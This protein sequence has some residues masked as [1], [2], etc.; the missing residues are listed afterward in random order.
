MT[1]MKKQSIR[2]WR[3][4]IRTKNVFLVGH[5]MQLTNLALPK[6]MI[7]IEI[8]LKIRILNDEMMQTDIRLK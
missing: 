4:L 8:T 6:M 3:L 2:M 7:Q 1:K 5:A